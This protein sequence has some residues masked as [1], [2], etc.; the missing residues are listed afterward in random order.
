MFV[1]VPERLLY[2][3]LKSSVASISR[4]AGTFDKSEKSPLNPAGNFTNPPL[5]K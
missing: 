4:F 2:C 3:P 5:I 1:G